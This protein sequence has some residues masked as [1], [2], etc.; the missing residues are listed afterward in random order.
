[1]ISSKTL[2][3]LSCKCKII[4]STKNYT[5]LITAQCCAVSYN[6]ANKNIAPLLICTNIGHLTFL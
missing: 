6:D 5:V 3:S 2:L 4:K 1:M